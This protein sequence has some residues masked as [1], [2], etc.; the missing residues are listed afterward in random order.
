MIGEK[1]QVIYSIITT[2]NSTNLHTKVEKWDVKV[3]H[4]QTKFNSM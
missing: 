2:C 4:R 1:K 3:I